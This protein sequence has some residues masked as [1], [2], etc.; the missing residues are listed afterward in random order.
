MTDSSQNRLWLKLKPY[1]FYKFGQ[2]YIFRKIS[3][4]NS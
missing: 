1:E 2:K 3:K 4:K